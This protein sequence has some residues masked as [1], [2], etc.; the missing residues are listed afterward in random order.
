M[1]DLQRPVDFL[2]KR[3][4]WKIGVSIAAA[5]VLTPVIGLVLLVLAG[6]L[7]PAVPMLAML[8]AGSSLRGWHSALPSTRVG[9]SLLLGPPASHPSA[10]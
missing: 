10:P 9:P 4:G 5:I 8:F 6:A 2:L 3:K 1:K 7:L